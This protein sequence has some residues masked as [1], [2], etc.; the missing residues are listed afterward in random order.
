MYLYEARKLS[1]LIPDVNLRDP[2]GFDSLNMFNEMALLS[3]THISKL[4]RGLQ[5]LKDNGVKGIV[6]GG[7]AVVHYVSGARDLTPDLDLMVNNL[8]QI[9][10]RLS[11]QKIQYSPLTGGTSKQIGKFGGIAGIQIQEFDMDLLD[12]KDGNAELNHLIM[13]TALPAKIGSADFS[14]ISPEML[15][16]QKVEMGGGEKNMNDA[17][18]ILQSGRINSQKYKQYINYLTR[19]GAL[20]EED[21]EDLNTYHDL[22]SSQQRQT[23]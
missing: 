11:T 8:D 12:A 20:D 18:L 10:Q 5:W 17:H 14:V 1:G 7:T 3:P 23:A 2:S 6:I 19:L 16:I 22:F 15:V 9:K 4:Q 13:T 21:V